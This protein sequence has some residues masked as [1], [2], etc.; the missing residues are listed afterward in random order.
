MD[1]TVNEPLAGV[2]LGKIWERYQSGTYPYD[3]YQGQLPQ[4]Y[5]PDTLK[6]GGK[7]EAWYWMVM[8]LW[9]RG[10]I[11]STDAAK[12]LKKLFE[13]LANRRCL[14]LFVPEQAAR[15]KPGRIV[16]LLEQ[17]GLGMHQV[18]PNLVRNAACLVEHWD[19]DVQAIF[20]GVASLADPYQVCYDRL[21]ESGF[22]GFRYKITSMLLYFL[23]ERGLI[24]EFPFPPPV[25]F[26]LQRVAVATAIIEPRDGR[27]VIAYS[28]RGYDQLEGLLRP[29]YL[30]Y[31][32]SREIPGNRMTD[33][34]WVL[35]RTLCRRYPGNRT[36]QIGKNKA[37]STKLEAH[38]PDWTKK[39]ALKAFDI[40]CGSCPVRDHCPYGV[41]SGP[42]YKLGRLIR[43]PRSEP[44]YELQAPMPGAV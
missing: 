12:S 28:Q 21:Q 44:P 27:D 32:L 18:A 43:I 35:S 33:M 4:N 22:E 26:H 41:P 11:N 14:N 20:E 15:M 25:D 17:A 3:N 38:T 30:D 19:G 13:N 40:S 37:R 8:C 42:R 10:G 24:K 34:L 36:R 6:L 23:V 9:M 31:A 1:L 2:V 39:T 29:L 5:I 7:E 16:Q